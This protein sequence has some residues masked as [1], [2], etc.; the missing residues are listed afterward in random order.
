MAKAKGTVVAINKNEAASKEIDTLREV[1][2]KLDARAYTRHGLLSAL[3]RIV[4]AAEEMVA[5]LDA[6]PFGF[7]IDDTAPN[8]IKIEQDEEIYELALALDP[9]IKRTLATLETLEDEFEPSGDNELA[10]WKWNQ[11]C[12]GHDTARFDTSDASFRIG[13]IFGAHLVGATPEQITRLK[14]GLIRYETMTVRH[15]K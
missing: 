1:W 2:D 3:E 14:N 15:Y 10:L 9:G 4:S 12:D 6:V 7:T 11:L 8:P 5:S 13:I